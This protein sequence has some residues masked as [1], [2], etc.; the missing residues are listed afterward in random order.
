MCPAGAGSLLS[1]RPRGV[2]RSTEGRSG[3]AALEVAGGPRGTRPRSGYQP[4]LAGP[5]HLLGRLGSPLPV[6]I[7]TTLTSQNQKSLLEDKF[8]AFHC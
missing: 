6:V 1:G 2:Q 8:V 3:G 7:G 5:R 4:R